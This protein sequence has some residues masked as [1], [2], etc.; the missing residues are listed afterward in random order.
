MRV[1]YDVKITDQT[2]S[3]GLILSYEFDVVHLGWGLCEIHNRESYDRC[4]HL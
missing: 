2:R 4:I 1:D 3:Y